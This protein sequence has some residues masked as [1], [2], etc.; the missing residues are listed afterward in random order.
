MKYGKLFFDD[1]IERVNVHWEDGSYG[2]GFHCGEV[3]DAYIPVK[4]TWEPYRIEYDHAEKE[5][6][7]VG[8]GSI[9]VCTEIRTTK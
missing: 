3:L 1:E 5:W 9:P 6:Y 8:L 2:D 7:F 4:G